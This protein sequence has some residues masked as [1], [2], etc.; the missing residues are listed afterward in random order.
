MCLGEAPCSAGV[1]GGL[2]WQASLHGRPLKA[3]NS[4]GRFARRRPLSP[5]LA[6][7]FAFGCPLARQASLRA[8]SGQL[9]KRASGLACQLDLSAGRMSLI[10]PSAQDSRASEFLILKIRILIRVARLREPLL[11]PSL[12]SWV[13]RH[14]ELEIEL[15]R[16]QSI[17]ATVWPQTPGRAFA[18]S[19]SIGAAVISPRLDIISIS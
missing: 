18:Y 17:D 5:L 1:R 4:A 9:G 19:I 2:V 13:A 12:G 10:R 11:C 15:D 7:P 6:V 16:R 8:A 14:S 3:I